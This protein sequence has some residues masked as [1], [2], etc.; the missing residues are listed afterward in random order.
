M[1]DATPDS[2]REDKFQHDRLPAAHPASAAYV[3]RL[4]QMDRECCSCC[5]VSGDAAKGNNE[6]LDSID[7]CDRTVAGIQKNYRVW[8]VLIDE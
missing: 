6:H 5:I 1:C 3:H 8:T 4:G 7:S 2:K